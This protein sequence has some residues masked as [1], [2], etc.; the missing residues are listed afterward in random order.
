MKLPVAIL[1]VLAIALFVGS[2][3]NDRSIP[4]DPLLPD[5]SGGAQGAA[6]GTQLFSFGW[7]H[8]GFGYID[9]MQLDPRTGKGTVTWS[10]P[11]DSAY[12][13]YFQ[14]PVGL[15][16]D[17]NGDMYV[18]VNYFDMNFTSQFSRLCLV[19]KGTGAITYV[20]ST[21]PVV[22]WGPD[23][24]SCGNLYGFG[25]VSVNGVYASAYLYQ[26]DKYTGVATKVG[27]NPPPAEHMDYMDLA[28]D[29]QDRLWTTTKNK[30]FRFDTATGVATYVMDVTGIPG[31]VCD[32]S[33][34]NYPGQEIMMLAFDDH[35][36]LYASA[37]NANTSEP[38]PVMTIDLRS[39]HATVIGYTGQLINHGG[40]I[41]PKMVRV[42]HRQG[43]G[44][45]TCIIINMRDLAAHLAHG[46][47]VPGTGGHSC[48]CP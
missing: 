31:A 47:Y 28:F 4:T 23:I 30:L 44:S 34:P 1:L 8:T 26:I 11:F 5:I 43:N 37:M 2:C 27:G 17:L 18:L 7:T 19:D 14:T 33:D 41:M 16:Y 32:P 35:D 6:G 40:D 13:D 3:S 38:G 24:D 9:Y 10:L 15:T 29:S 39:G 36:V 48:D 20:G 25:G 22:F 42:A 46:D 21:I 45:Y 12:P